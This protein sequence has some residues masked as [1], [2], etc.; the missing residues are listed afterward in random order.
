MRRCPSAVVTSPEVD[1]CVEW[2]T[3]A[4]TARLTTTDVWWRRWTC[5][6]S[7]DEHRTSTGSM[8][9]NHT[10]AVWSP[11]SSRK[12][13]CVFADQFSGPGR[14]DDRV[15]VCA[16]TV[17]FERNDCWPRYLALGSSWPYT[18]PVWRSR[19][20]WQVHGHKKKNVPFR[21]WLHVIRRGEKTVAKKQTWI[22]NCK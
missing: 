21:L 2:T 20:R 11:A 4:A 14:A 16:R 7:V 19:W 3:A 12:L 6:E 18:D 5:L 9:T 17:T 8:L 15:F 10:A 1:T 13:Q 22:W